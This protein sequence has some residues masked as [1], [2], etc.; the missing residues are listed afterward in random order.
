MFKRK[1]KALD[2]F[3]RES[4]DINSQQDIK[5][6]VVWLEDQ[7]IRHYKIEEREAL[8]KPNDPTWQ[9]NFEKYL[10]DVGCPFN[11]SDKHAVIDWLL[12]LAVRL[13]YGDNSERYKD[14]TAENVRNKAN[15]PVIVQKNPLDNLNFDSPEFKAGVASLAQLFKITQHPDHLVTLQAIC[16]FVRERLSSE[17]SATSKKEG[18]PYP[19]KDSP[20]GFGTGDYVLDYAAKILRLLYINDL[21]NLQTGINEAIVAVQAIT[22]NPKTDTRLGKVGK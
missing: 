2:Y 17:T 15:A 1:L 6:L 5:S 10:T 13:D 14:A 3:N 8:R 22:A 21:R 12:G 11:Y 7:K 19:L 20:L 9:S 4:F 16:T 18:T